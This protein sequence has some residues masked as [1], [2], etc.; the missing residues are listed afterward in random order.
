MKIA[1]PKKKASLFCEK[2]FQITPCMAND[3]IYI[4]DP[5]IRVVSLIKNRDT[6][7]GKTPVYDFSPILAAIRQCT[8]PS[9]IQ[10]TDSNTAS[11]PHQSDEPTDQ[12][13]K[14]IP[15]FRSHSPYPTNKGN[16][17]H[18]PTPA[19]LCLSGNTK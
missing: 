15:Y 2:V 16:K 14:K 19:S 5:W 9:K 1:P 6:Q 4:L 12:S 18:L 11:E 7:E 17:I 3:N 13:P 10:K 8:E